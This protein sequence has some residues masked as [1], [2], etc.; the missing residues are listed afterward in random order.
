MNQELSFLR[1][2]LETVRNNRADLSTRIRLAEVLR[3]KVASRPELLEQLDL[4]ADELNR[5]PSR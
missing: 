2:Y 5:F 4:T 3:N 1:S